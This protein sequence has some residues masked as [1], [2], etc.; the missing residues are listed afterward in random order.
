MSA[1]T[2]ATQPG[3]RP[4]A[5]GDDV[6]LYDRRKRR[7]RI[8]LTPGASYYSHLGSILHDDLIGREE[9]LYIQTNRGHR[10]LALRPTF[11]EAV[12]D[13]PRQS[14]VIYPKDLAAIL[15]HANVF[16]GA[17]V[18]ELGLGSG[19]MSAALLRAV[20]PTGTLTTYE[21]RPEIVDAASANIQSLAPG[22]MNQTIVVADAY[23]HGIPQEGLDSIVADLPEPWRMVEAAAGALRP[24]G[25][26]LSYLPTVL[27]VHQFVMAL[28]MDQRWRLV[29][30]VELLERPWHVTD[31]SVR[32]EHRMVSHT[33]FITTARRCAPPPVAEP[34]LAL[35]S[36]VDAEASEDAEG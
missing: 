8:K 11:R 19:A 3:Y 35:A 2:P 5:A 7:Y 21:M 20:G 36:D 14:Q 26:Y 4:L 9:G 31:Q 10:I 29:E 16:P 30:T 32:P 33:G 6:V 27:Q 34:E 24:G 17:R 23:E 25:I 15:M 18:A 13:L 22:T 28:T 1:P 12:L